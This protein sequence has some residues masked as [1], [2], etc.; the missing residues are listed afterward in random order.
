V[1]FQRLSSQI[2]V[3]EGFWLGF[4]FG[5]DLRGIRELESQATEMLKE[6]GKDVDAR[7][8]PEPDDDPGATMRWLLTPRPPA[9]GLVW[10]VAT[11]GVGD[12]RAWLPW[13]LRLLR[14]LNERRDT[15]RTAVPCGVVLAGP[16]DLLPIARDT[17]PDLWSYRSMLLDLSQRWLP[18]PAPMPADSGKLDRLLMYGPDARLRLW[19]DLDRRGTAQAGRGELRRALATHK[20]ALALALRMKA[21]SESP[22]TLGNAVR[23]MRNVGRG[24]QELGDLDSALNAYVDAIR[25]AQ[26]II[27]LYGETPDALRT[28]SE[29]LNA[30]AEVQEAQGDL[31][32]ARAR[33]REAEQ[34]AQRLP[35]PPPTST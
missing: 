33:R 24:Y 22:R 10:L 27:A 5:A 20:E 28:V 1:S 12:P 15:L 32:A 6:A 19:E 7:Y 13:W 8:L 9:T 17:A 14:R 31:D 23:S 16:S 34:I 11:G 29:L 18:L 3:S 35:D 30:A 26:H 4:I 21:D 25:V 2:A